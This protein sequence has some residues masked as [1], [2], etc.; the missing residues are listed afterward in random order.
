MLKYLNSYNKTLTT[1]FIIILLLIILALF[2]PYISPYSPNL[3]ETEAQLLSPSMQHWCGTDNLGRDIL[4]RIIWGSRISLTIV[5]WVSLMSAPLG[6]LLGTV[7]GLMGGNLEK[8]IMSITNLFLSFPKLILAMTF[9][10]ALGPGIN[11]AILA[12]S[13]TSWAPYAR[14]ARTETL[15]I[16]HASF[17]HAIRLQGASN[18]RII[19]RHIIPMCLPSILVRVNLDMAGFILTAAG[20]GFLGLGA[21]P[22]APEWG[23]MV[24][25]GREFLLSHWWIMTLPG[26]AIF[27]VSLGFNLLGEGLRD[28][29]DPKQEKNFNA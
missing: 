12:I 25:S 17:I 19:M 2:A 27:I 22:P 9:I 4:S 10:A 26:A 29:L 13:L 8:W 20:L 16:K 23:A 7:S 18:F 15:S 28:A 21:L 14:L 11:N 24:A 5:L 3:I 6:L 1:G